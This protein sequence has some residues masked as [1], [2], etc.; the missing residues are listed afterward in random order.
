PGRGFISPAEFIPVAEEMGLIMEIGRWVLHQACSQTMQWRRDL[1]EVRDL[2]VSINVSVRQF[3]DPLF[4]RT[5][6]KVLTETQLPPHALKLEITESVIME[7]VDL[8]TETLDKLRSLGLRL[9]LDDFGTG[10]SSL[11]YLHQ[12][13]MNILKIDQSFIRNLIDSRGNFQ[14]V[15]TI[16]MMAE[17]F[18]MTAIA[19]G[20][21]NQ[22]QIDQ[23]RDM[24]CHEGQGYFFSPPV[25]AADATVLLRHNR[26]ALDTEVHRPEPVGS[27]AGRT[28]RVT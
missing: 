8:V 26:F 15:R 24:S 9:S 6:E 11:S 25:A 21:E 20:I 17:N 10:Y 23:L 4:I 3:S 2:A 14:L 5:I 16:L 28:S 19:E 13:P 7:N 12:F 22:R 1:P 27:R 18:G